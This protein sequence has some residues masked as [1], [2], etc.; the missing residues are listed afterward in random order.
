[1]NLKEKKLLYV[2]LTILVIG[3]VVQGI[4]FAIKA[5]NSS[6]EEIQELKEK[7]SR[8]K[9]LL[10]REDYWQIEYEKNNKKVQKL[11]SLLY[12]GGSP[13]LMAGRVQAKLKKLT[14]ISDIKVD[15]MSLPD[16]K[17]VDNWLLI[18]QSM[19]F[20]ASAKS[21]MQLLQLIG[22]AKPKLIVTDLKVRSYRKILNC[23]IKVVGFSR[24]SESE[25]REG[26]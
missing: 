23:T 17:Q 25:Q 7:R 19:S 22:N 12:A 2:F 18:S 11:T 16:L 9:K 10:V 4:P 20:K 5:Y 8:L 1:M 24:F 21:L 13:D 6:N 14:K 26:S 15:S 3:I